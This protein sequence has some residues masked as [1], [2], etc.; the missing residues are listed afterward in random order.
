MIYCIALL[1]LSVFLTA[2]IPTVHGF[3]TSLKFGANNESYV[4]MMSDLSPASEEITVCSW[5]KRMSSHRSDK[6]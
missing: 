1:V 3:E 6:E 4:L 2:V 5:V